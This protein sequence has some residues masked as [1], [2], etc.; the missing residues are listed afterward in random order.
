MA[1]SPPTLTLL[2]QVTMVG[3]GGRSQVG[4]GEQGFRQGV[5][6]AAVEVVV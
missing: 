4:D 1:N 3:H 2:G 5:S 6:L